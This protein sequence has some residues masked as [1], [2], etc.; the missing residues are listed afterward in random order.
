MDGAGVPYDEERPRD[1]ARS[2]ASTTTSLGLQ[3]H[4]KKLYIYTF[5]N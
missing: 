1:A 3:N 4:P 5:V 2:D